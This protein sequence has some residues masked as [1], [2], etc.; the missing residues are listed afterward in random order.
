MPHLITNRRKTTQF[1]NITIIKSLEII[2]LIIYITI[3][4][5]TVWEKTFGA[6]KDPQK[7]KEENKIFFIVW[8]SVKQL[9]H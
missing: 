3:L 8:M 7:G 2:T 6:F 5:F 1:L 4:L 9:I